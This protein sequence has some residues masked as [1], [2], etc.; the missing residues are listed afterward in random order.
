MSI[1]TPHLLANDIWSICNLWKNK[2]EKS[3]YLPA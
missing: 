3:S 2:T 1:E